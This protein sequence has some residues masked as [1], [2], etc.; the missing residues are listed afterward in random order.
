M[1][2]AAEW[3][4]LVTC[5]VTGLS[6]LLQPRAWAEAFAALSRLG[7]PGAFINGGVNLVPGAAYIATHPVWSG[8]A[9]VLTVLGWLLVL[10]GAVCFLAPDLALRSMA[11]GGAGHGRGFAAGGL[12]LLGVAGVLGYA[13][14]TR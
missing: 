2:R 10:K 14:W 1:E 13:L 7:R 12:V 4:A 11:R 6:H 8:P 3:F 5:A 9:V